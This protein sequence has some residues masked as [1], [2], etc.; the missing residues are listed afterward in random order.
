MSA[1]R[2]GEARRGVKR[3]FPATKPRLIKLRSE[4]SQPLF[5]AAVTADKRAADPREPKAAKGAEQQRKSTAARK[6]SPLLARRRLIRNCS[7]RKRA[8]RSTCG[9]ITNNSR[10]RWVETGESNALADNKNACTFRAS[11]SFPF[12]EYIG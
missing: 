11:D 7:T 8:T 4:Q 12:R 3:N 2:R 9:Q 10:E 6:S 1:S 5:D